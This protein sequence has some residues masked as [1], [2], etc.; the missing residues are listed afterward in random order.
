MESWDN[1][2]RQVYST[3][4]KTIIGLLATLIEEAGLATFCVLAV[5]RLW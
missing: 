2:R 1:I 5:M 3:V 4:S